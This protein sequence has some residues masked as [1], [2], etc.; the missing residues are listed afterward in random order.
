M[1]LGILRSFSWFIGFP[2]FVSTAPCSFA[3]GSVSLGLQEVIIPHT[4]G[5]YLFLRPRSHLS[6]DVLHVA[7]FPWLHVPLS[8]PSTLWQLCHFLFPSFVGCSWPIKTFLLDLSSSSRFPAVIG[9]SW[10]SRSP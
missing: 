5:S 4:L 8:E 2:P 6:S 1:F 7:H 3:H 10:P 9:C